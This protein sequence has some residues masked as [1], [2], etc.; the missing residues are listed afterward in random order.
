MVGP[1]AAERGIVGSIVDEGGS[2]IVRI[3]LS[4]IGWT[5]RRRRPSNPVMR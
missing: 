3:S 1:K 5:E 4:A 2:R